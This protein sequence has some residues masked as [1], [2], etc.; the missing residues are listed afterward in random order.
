M[1]HLTILYRS[2]ALILWVIFSSLIFAQ[3]ALAANWTA[4]A[5]N[6]YR[7]SIRAEYIPRIDGVILRILAKGKDLQVSVYPTYISNVSKGIDALRTKP[8]YINNMEITSI[9][10]YISYELDGVSRNLASND[11]FFNDLMQVIDGTSAS[12]VGTSTGSS[13]N[14]ANGGGGTTT[15]SGS[16]GASAGIPAGACFFDTAMYQ[17]RG[18]RTTVT[19]SDSTAW[20]T[21]NNMTVV[22]GKMYML[23]KPGMSTNFWKVSDNSIS[24]ASVSCSN[25]VISESGMEA[26]PRRNESTTTT[27]A[28]NIING[29]TTTPVG[30]ATMSMTCAGNGWDAVVSV[31]LDSSLS[32]SYVNI[33]GFN[34]AGAYA[35]DSTLM[36]TDSENAPAGK[37]LR[38]MA[39]PS[40]S[41]A[42]EFRLKVWSDSSPRQTILKSGCTPNTFPAKPEIVSAIYNSISQT[43][44]VT[45]RNSITTDIINVF[46]GNNTYGSLFWTKEGDT[47]TASLADPYYAGL[48]SLIQ[49]GWSHLKISGTYTGNYYRGIMSNSPDK[50]LFQIRADADG[51]VPVILFNRTANGVLTNTISN[52]SKRYG[53]SWSTA[54]TTS[55]KFVC[56][57]PSTS[58]QINKEVALGL[59]NSWDETSYNDLIQWGWTP[60]TYDC[61][62][63]GTGNTGKT[64]TVKHIFTIE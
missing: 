31:V 13:T 40:S 55:L 10:K 48:R 62:I 6:P 51:T 9:I 18:L 25:G 30:N 39:I 24:G 58:T 37:S 64:T 61:D 11:S 22:A 59:Q 12:S 63:I 28:S 5:N 36:Y 3:G 45:T 17:A 46:Q 8:E 52:D 27:G 34:A 47:W 42:T 15:A 35:L 23:S 7:S 54:H 56:K 41:V 44:T 33:Q 38:I 49:S 4:S 53:V 14:V 16:T 29:G 60:G 21:A 50:T 57:W 26:F 1:S 19:A 2:I 43:V 20:L 32:S